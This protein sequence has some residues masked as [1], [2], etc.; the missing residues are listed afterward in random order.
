MEQE[1]INEHGEA[2]RQHMPPEYPHTLTRCIGQETE[3]RVD[4]TRLQIQPGDR[5]LLCTDGLNKVVPE[6]EIAQTLGK[7]LSSEEITTQLTE[8]ANEQSGPDNITI[9]TLILSD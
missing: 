5:I 7:D 8:T 9:I 6:S 2:A 1:L 3:L 4:Q